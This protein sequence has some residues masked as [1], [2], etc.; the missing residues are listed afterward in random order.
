MSLR[1][2]IG[3]VYLAR[4]SQVGH[5]ACVRLLRRS[6]A[7]AARSQWYWAIAFG[8]SIC[9]VLLWIALPLPWALLAGIIPLALGSSVLLAHR[10]YELDHK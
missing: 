3:A 7:L 8:F 10:R 5:N 1:R 9:F 4:A 6:F 2:A